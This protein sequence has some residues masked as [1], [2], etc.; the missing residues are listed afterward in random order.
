MDIVGP[1]KRTKKGHKFILTVMDFAT[2]YPEAIPLKK[3]D[4]PTVAEALCQIFSRMGIPEEVLSNQ[5]TNFLS[6]TMTTIFELLQIH[7]IKT[8]PYHPQTNGMLE[9]FHGTL[10]GMLRKTSLATE[11]WD[12]MLPY[13]C[14]AYCEVPHA[15]TGFSP[16][17]LLFGRNVRGPLSM[18]KDQWTG[19]VKTP[20]SVVSFVLQLQ[21][22]L[23]KTAALARDAESQAKSRSKSWYDQKARQRQFEKGDQVLALLPDDSTN[24]SPQWHGP[25]AIMEQISPVTYKV[26]VPERRKKIRLIH[27]NML[28]PWKTPSNVLS[29]MCTQEP[30]T[31]EGELSLYTLETSLPDN[32][33]INPD[34]SNTQ[35]AELLSLLGTLGETLKDTPGRTTLASHKIRTNGAAPIHQHPYRIPAAWQTA[36]REEI[37][38]MLNLG[39][40]EPSDSPWASPIVAVKKKDG[41]LRLCVDYRKVNAVTLED[42]YQMPR[43]EELIEN[44]G[45]SKYI[46]TLD[47]TKGYYQVPVEEDDRDKTAFTTPVGKYRFITMPFRL[48]GA[49][50]TFQRLMDQVLGDCYG[51]ASTYLD[52]IVIYSH[53][54]QEHLEHITEVFRR[55]HQAGLTVKLKK[56]QFGMAQRSYLGHVVGKGKIQ[57]EEGKIEAV[58]NF[59]VPKTKK[60]LRA[61]LGLIGYY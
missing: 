55:L 20:Q 36:V 39:I 18:I 60:D 6:T 58:Q 42:T 57:P 41:S 32:P 16:F 33:S 12:I 53:S 7:H 24:L 54:W 4:A 26:Y 46:T 1:L 3:V 44:L 56:C 23:A 14:F 17:E 47:L 35:K 45:K 48:K 25:Y 43:V 11:E 29:V 19:K 61:F 21:E 38:T 52:D 59:A 37:Q 8:S 22:Q 10:K 15:A 2:R 34:L 40:I 5:G 51:Y 30:E 49:P 27:V 28:K 31:D 50:T 13:I 9:R